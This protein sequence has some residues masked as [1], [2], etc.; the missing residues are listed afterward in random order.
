MLA[1]QGTHPQAVQH[2]SPATST[3]MQTRT[4]SDTYCG[5]CEMLNHCR[6]TCWL[7]AMCACM[8]AL[9][10]I[11]KRDQTGELPVAQRLHVSVAA[12]LE[13]LHK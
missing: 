8:L 12:K 1:V 4:D 13:H 3:C 2:L 9:S 5:Y 6:H 7:K 11:V 10:E